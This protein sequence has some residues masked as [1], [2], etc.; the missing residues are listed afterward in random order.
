MLAIAAANSSGNCILTDHLVTLNFGRDLLHPN[1]RRS[2]QH[3]AG[4]WG[5]Q[6]L[7]ITESE[8]RGFAA[9]LRLDLISPEGRVIFIDRDTV[10]STR[11]PNPLEIV[12]VGYFGYV[13]ADQGRY[14][15]HIRQM[16]HVSIFNKWAKTLGSDVPYQKHLYFNSGLMVFDM[17]LHGKVFARARQAIGPDTEKV[18]WHEE[19]GCVSASVAMDC[20]RFILPKVFNCLVRQN[21]LAF[22]PLPMSAYI[23]HFAGLSVKKRIGAAVLSVWDESGLDGIGDYR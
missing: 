5:V 9:K 13:L 15:E 18:L 22:R 6:F 19:Q 8:A 17:P 1:S 14:P 16:W 12:P 7:E 11:C 2:M 4:R 23:Y 21:K 10:I 20:F 3:A